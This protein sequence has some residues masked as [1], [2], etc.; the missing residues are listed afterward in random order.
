MVRMEKRIEQNRI[1][2][3]G[4]AI[5][6][7]RKREGITVDQL[8]NQLGVSAPHLR[9][10]ELEHKPMREELIARTAQALNCQISALR[11]AA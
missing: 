9:N 10:I 6:E 2:Q 7:I 4:S 1:P 5:R 11:R 8:A 3:N